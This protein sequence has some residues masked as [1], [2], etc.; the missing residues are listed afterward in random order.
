MV[1]GI[2]ILSNGKGHFDPTDQNDQT[3]ESIPK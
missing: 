3:S 1:L 2:R